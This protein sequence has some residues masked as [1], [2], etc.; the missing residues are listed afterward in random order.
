MKKRSSFPAY[1]LFTAVLLLAGCTVPQPQVCITN[2]AGRQVCVTVEVADTPDQ[3]N[4]GLMYRRHLG[5]DSGMLF[6]FSTQK[7]NSFTMKNTFIP[8]DML[9][10]DRSLRVAGVIENTRPRTRGPYRIEKPSQ[11]VLEV[12]ALFCRKHDIAA[13]C[14]VEL[15]NIPE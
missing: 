14:A 2:T 3:R 7:L 13:G 15:K 5:R 12:N 4:L 1:S 8:L 10:I 9:F 6:V 11:Y